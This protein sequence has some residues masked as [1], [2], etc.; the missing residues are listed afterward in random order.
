MVHKTPSNFKF[1]DLCSVSER[2]EGKRE[3]QV[4]PIIDDLSSKFLLYSVGRQLATFSRIMVTKYFFQRAMVIKMMP[5]WIA[6]WRSWGWG[7]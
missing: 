5:A 1:T 4:M 3:R 2:Q 7:G 6:L